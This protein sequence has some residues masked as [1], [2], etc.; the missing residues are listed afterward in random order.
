MKKY[1]ADDRNF[2]RKAV[3]WAL[4]N[5]GKRNMALNGRAIEVA[6]EI[7]VI[8]SKT[9]RW[10]AADALRELQSEKVMQRLLAKG[11]KGKR[12]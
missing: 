2:V 4:R 1:A 10:I 6:R 7:R 3:S 12:K 8:D 5:I 11:S 9:A